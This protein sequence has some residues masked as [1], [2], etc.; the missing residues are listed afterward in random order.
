MSAEREPVE[1]LRFHAAPAPARASSRLYAQGV[2]LL[3]HKDSVFRQ[4]GL[5]RPSPSVNAAA[6]AA[7]P[8]SPRAT[9]TTQQQRRGPLA[10]PAQPAG[11]SRRAPRGARERAASAPYAPDRRALPAGSAEARS[12]SLRSTVESR[13]LVSPPS[14]A[15]GSQ[16]H[17]QHH[18]HH[19]SHY[20][21]KRPASASEWKVAAP[22][23]SKGAT[24]SCARKSG[25][26]NASAVWR[27]GRP[28][29]APYL[30]RPWTSGGSSSAVSPPNNLSAG[31][32]TSGHPTSGAAHRQQQLQPPL[33]SSAARAGRAA[34]S[35][36]DKSTSGGVA[37][38][39][40]GPASSKR[41]SVLR[42]GVPTTFTGALPGSS[43]A[44]VTL[45]QV[46]RRTSSPI[47]TPSVAEFGM[48]KRPSVSP[49]PSLQHGADGTPQAP[50]PRASLLVRRDS[51]MERLLEQV[52]VLKASL[53]LSDEDL[54]W[55][56]ES[57][58]GNAFLAAERHLHD[59][60]ERYDRLVYEV[61]LL[62]QTP[63]EDASAALV[64][65]VRAIMAQALAVAA[66]KPALAA[67]H[68]DVARLK[69]AIFDARVASELQQAATTT[70]GESASGGRADD[71]ADDRSGDT[72][73]DAADHPRASADPV[74]EL[75]RQLEDAKARILQVHETLR[76]DISR[77]NDLVV[78]LGGETDRLAATCAAFTYLSPEVADVSAQLVALLRRVPECA[79]GGDKLLALCEQ[80]VQTAQRLRGSRL[81]DLKR[82][83]AE[84][85]AAI[86]DLEVWK[87]RRE[88]AKECAAELAQREQQWR[89]DHAADNDAARRLLRGLVPLDVQQLS[90]EAIIARAA[91]AGVLYTFDLAIYVKQNRFLHWLVTHASDVARDNFLALES[92][93]HFLNFA[94]LD[95]FELRA[96]STALPLSAAGGF[97]F[98][99]DGRKAAWKAQFLDHVYALVARER[100]E[101]V[102]AG[103]DPVRRARGDVPLPPLADKQLL[104]AV[105]R[106]PSD[107]EIAARVAKFE[108][109]RERLELK[110]EKLRGLEAALIPAAKAEYLA[111]AEDAR[112][113]ALQRSFGRATLVRL[114]DD[115]KQ[116]LQALAKTRDALA[117]EV[118]H[119]ER[120]WGA[121]CPTFAQFLDEA[122]KVRA[123]DPATRAARIRGPFPPD[124]ELRP[125]ARAAF[126][127]LSV[128]EEAQAR[129]HEL[130]RAIASRGK[131]ISDAAAG[132][133]AQTTATTA[134]TAEAPSEAIASLSASLLSSSSST[135]VAVAAVAQKS[136]PFRRVKSLEVSTEVLQFLQQD[137]CSSQRV[138]KLA[139][140]ANA[141]RAAGGGASAS[142]GALAVTAAA[143]RLKRFASDAQGGEA[144]PA[145][146]A[147]A[148]PVKPK[149][150]A[151][152]ELL[153]RGKEAAGDAG[154]SESSGA[155]RP[156]SPLKG[157]MFSELQSRAAAKKSS[158]SSNTAAGELEGGAAPPARAQ[159]AP[160]NFLDEL[161][162]KAAT[163]LAKADAPSPPPVRERPRSPLEAAALPPAPQSF[164][165]ELRA[166]ARSID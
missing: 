29:D 154:G 110:R 15:H 136:G 146:A 26:V 141:G 96:L 129:R 24:A 94:A 158:S 147:P 39:A 22:R 139:A 57:A 65:R 121:L 135:V 27:S 123:L 105:Y 138:Q 117:S 151:L 66:S 31:R 52:T 42:I 87:T 62:S 88:Q 163:G 37:A 51:K 60:E 82:K 132:A 113:D 6:A 85:A 46:S 33:P 153:E 144:P 97:E 102:K 48:R 76:D 21:H 63:C 20:P 25:V 56:V 93:A 131:E 149:S 164:L 18:H 61:Q 86:K 74:A 116:A 84:L 124:A 106:Y 54:Q 55:K 75:N 13:M 108:L 107:A 77:L 44:P 83:E 59:G 127:K 35:R 32:R 120:Q 140:A 80:V 137:F 92:A 50:Q 7:A 101:S 4:F 23:H 16:Q 17:Q 10:Q 165:D 126:K 53:G 73:T 68:S 67:G 100:G 47:L 156:P 45:V 98:D 155:V 12:F 157:N 95:V 111:I 150:K 109:Q 81:R 118:A 34:A 79:T 30:S 133:D 145:P 40:T 41:Q 78:A 11:K 115:A 142:K 134:A 1:Q 3:E 90:V 64:K 152:L 91:S 162:R 2:R 36:R 72:A 148:A 5:L 49:I 14:K 128:E 58:K 119:A 38:G 143:L 103:W 71:H 122:A 19:H 160:V 70:A 9:A 161:K 125:R 112:S 159:A 166:R 114:R 89:L 99:R 28:G 8:G 69:K 130:D 104:N 43:A